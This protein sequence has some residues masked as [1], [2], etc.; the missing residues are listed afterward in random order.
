MHK[1][2]TSSYD[3]S[4]YLQQ[5]EQNSGLD[6]IIE[7]GKTYYGSIKD[8]S[9]TLIKFDI[10]PISQSISQ[11]VISSSFQSF[12]VLK[13]AR[14]EEI[15]LNYTIHANAVSQSWTMGTGTKFDNLS[16]NGV[17]WKYRDGYTKWQENTIGGS[18]VY[19]VGTTGSANAEG[20]TWYTASQASQSFNY[21]SD[22]VRMD[23]TGLVKLWLSGSVP[24]EGFIIHHS[25]ENEENT[26]DY[27]VL[28]FYSKETST[29][30]EPK[31]EFV[32]NDFIFT[33]GS[34][35]QMPTSDYKISFV[36]LKS[37]YQKDSKV[38]IRLKGRELYPLKSFTT[39]AFEYDQTKYLPTSSYYQLED[40]VT[41]DVLIPFSNYTKISCDTSGSFFNLDLNTLQQTRVYKLK[42]K[43][44]TDGVD[45]I[46]DDKYLFEIV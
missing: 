3:A 39:T 41:G 4:V 7:I 38:K 18:A 13:A 32:W 11:G 5:P 2:F 35:S 30:Y 25:L 14:S 23:V 28:R 1:F 45:N 40:E 34:L 16:S 46:L 6:E 15:P 9:R 10:T 26:I 43:I 36:N 29:I 33:T 27:G 20:G 21:Q 42:L 37:K 31:L 12:L 17:S 19:A 24:N 44:T 8:I 22:D